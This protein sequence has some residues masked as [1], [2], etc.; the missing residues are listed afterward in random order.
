MFDR[1]ETLGG[2]AGDALGWRVRGNQV[3]VVGFE[4]LELVQQLV[5]LRVGYLWC[6]E[7]VVAV[8]VVPD[9]LAE[10]LDTFEG[11]QFHRSREST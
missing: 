5:E 3:R 8:F 4:L 7:D 2:S 6:V 11:V 1:R 9:G 10:L